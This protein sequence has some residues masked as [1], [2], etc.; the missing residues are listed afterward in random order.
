MP[1]SGV[2]DNNFARGCVSDIFLKTI[3][4]A[5]TLFF[6]SGQTLSHILDYNMKEITQEY[7]AVVLK[8]KNTMFKQ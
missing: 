4:K 1:Q 6:L 2:E 5:I 3:C 8:G 7:K